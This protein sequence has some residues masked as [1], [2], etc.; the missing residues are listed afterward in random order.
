[1][2]VVR[3]TTAALALAWCGLVCGQGPL[4]A[5]A[6][7]GAARPRPY[8]SALVGNDFATLATAG[9]LEAIPGNTFT[10]FGNVDAS[11]L[12]GGGAVGL[13]VPRPV[14][15]LRMEIEGRGRGSFTGPTYLTQNGPGTEITLPLQVKLHDGWSALTNF[16]R[17]VFVTDTLGLYLGG[18]FGAGGYRYQVQGGDALLPVSGPVVGN[19]TITTFAWQAGTGIIWDV[20]DCIT[21]DLGYRFFS[22]GPGSTPLTSDNGAGISYLG[23]TS[24]SL[25]ASEVL[26][27]VRIY[28]PFRSLVR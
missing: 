25:S 26:F 2:I 22:Y 10:S 17:D 19:D 12:N 11:I 13:A 8:V 27:T 7:Q 9:S 16:W 20:S 28:E 15:Q 1:M 6:E 5:E 14:G 4:F 18:G 21:L 3:L 23:N 24:S